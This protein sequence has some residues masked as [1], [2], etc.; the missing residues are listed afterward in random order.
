MLIY[1]LCF[2][3]LLSSAHIF[4]V[5][6]GSDTAVSR[7]NTQQTLADGDRIA[8]FAALFGG[9]A[10]DGVAT[11]GIFDSFFQVSGDIDLNFGTLILNQDLVTQDVVRILSLGVIN[12]NGRTLELSPQLSRIPENDEL[13]NCS[14]SFLNSSA[15]NDQVNS[16]DWNSTGEYVAIA[17][18]DAGGAADQVEIYG[19][20]GSA[21]TLITGVDIDNDA[22][23]VRWHPT[24]D[25]IAVGRNGAAGS[26]FEEIFIYSFNGTTLTLLDSLTLVLDTANAVSWR[27]DGDFLAVA[28]NDAGAELRV[29]PVSG[30]GIIGTAITTGLAQA[31]N[32][33]SWNNDGSFLATVIDNDAG[34]DELLVYS[35]DGVSLALDSGANV[36]ATTN[37]VSWNK[38]GANDDIIAIGSEV[39]TGST[40]KLYR[41][42]TGVLTELAI[43]VSTTSPVNSVHWRTGGMCLAVGLDNNANGEVRTYEFASD[44]ISLASDIER[45]FNVFDVRWDRNGSYLASGSDEPVVSLFQHDASFASIVFSDI[46]IFLNNDLDWNSPSITFTGESSINGRGKTLSLSSTFSFIVASESSLLL[47]NMTLTGVKETSLLGID[48]QSTFSFQDVHMVLEEDFTFTLG[49]WD[50]LGDLIISGTSSVTYSSDQ[51]LIIRGDRVGS[52]ECDPFYKGALILEE[53]VTFNY[54]PLSGSSDLLVM[55]SSLSRLFLRGANFI[56]SNVTLTKGTVC[57]D[58]KSMINGLTNITLGDGLSF[59]NNCCLEIHSAANLDVFGTFIYNNV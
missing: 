28:S 49:S 16:V 58:G 36:T 30:A 47:K 14:I 54:M 11:T 20:D 15:T 52:D 31:A 27:P 46:N 9:F 26:P 22:L 8:G 40:L 21:L 5:D 43:S 59:A 13:S 7:F 18:N 19:W 48:A 53:G 3:L 45:G 42:S 12:G 2:L 56:A 23:S 39:G 33:V 10:L 38:E 24:N 44:D 51:N 4:G 17:I 57:V 1:K 55:E 29:Y 50:I 6:I 35:F 32:D 41:H 34:G 25:W 37:A